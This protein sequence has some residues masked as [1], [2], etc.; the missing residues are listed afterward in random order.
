MEGTAH[1]VLEAYGRFPSLGHTLDFLRL[2]SLVNHRL[3]RLSKHME[4]TTGVSGRQY[5]V[6][7]VVKQ[8]PNLSATQ[9]A[10]SL[11]VHPAT[12]TN[13]V[14]SMSRRE[15]L[16]VRS[17]SGDRRRV[18]IR[19]GS[20]GREI[21]NTITD[22]TVVALVDTLAEISTDRRLAAHDVLSQLADQLQSGLSATGETAAKPT[23]ALRLEPRK[24]CAAGVGADTLP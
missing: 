24:R 15:L 11:V 9:L 13:M 4:A 18:R 8:K 7:Q 19:L 5:L 6:L 10:A 17:D 2:L 22:M 14:R 16:N 3:A 12:L 21:Y 23:T 1:R 20:R